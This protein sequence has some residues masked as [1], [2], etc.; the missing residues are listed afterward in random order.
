MV[1][2]FFWGG[3]V[4]ASPNDRHQKKGW[5][6]FCEGSN[7]FVT[8][9]QNNS[10]I[11]YR[12]FFFP[13]GSDRRF[14][15]SLLRDLWI[16]RRRLRSHSQGSQALPLVCPFLT[17]G[18]DHDNKQCTPTTESGIGRVIF[19]SRSG[20]GG[21]CVI[22][23]VFVPWKILHTE[24]CSQCSGL[25]YRKRRAPSLASAT[26]TESG[27]S[28]DAVFLQNH[29]ESMTKGLCLSS[30]PLRHLLC[31]VWMKSV[32]FL[33]EGNGPGFLSD[34]ECWVDVRW[35]FFLSLP[36]TSEKYFFFFIRWQSIKKLWCANFFDRE[37]WGAFFRGQGEVRTAPHPKLWHMSSFA[38]MLIDTVCSGAGVGWLVDVLIQS[39]FIANLSSR[40]K[41]HWPCLPPF[42][43]DRRVIISF[44]CLALKF[45]WGIYVNTGLCL[46]C[47]FVVD[48]HIY[49]Y[50]FSWVNMQPSHTMVIDF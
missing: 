34:Y 18:T 44:I 38:L 29:W 17:E 14:S 10:V 9:S 13:F 2:T 37:F 40:T 3:Q 41:M 45:V 25:I 39:C 4:S 5:G 12:R 28:R 49:I 6:I 47:F 48:L 22:S 1:S 15:W 23:S 42:S 19:F 35:A 24:P 30:K 33:E 46:L 20:G 36:P 21:S 11:D 50:L 31:A 43:K 16:P 32:F 7:L 27:A 8:R 26:G